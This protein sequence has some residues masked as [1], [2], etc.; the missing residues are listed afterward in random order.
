MPSAV[1]QTAMK[2]ALILITLMTIPPAARAEYSFIAPDPSSC[3]SWTAERKGGGRS[4]DRQIWVLGFLSGVGSTKGLTVLDPL[5]GIDREAV[6]AWTDNFC[7]DHPLAEMAAALTV[8][9]REH[10]N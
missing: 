10:P 4:T 7:R 3:G 8:F 9:M 6:W 5:H 2:R 1:R